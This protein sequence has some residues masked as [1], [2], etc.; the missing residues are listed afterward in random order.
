MRNMRFVLL[1]LAPLMPLALAAPVQA[2]LQSCTVG[3]QVAMPAGYQDKWLQAV[4]I[5]VKPGDTHPC[6]AHPL[7]YTPYADFSYKPSA[8]RAME[9][10]P[11][12]P[13][14]GIVDDPHLLALKGQK[15]FKATRVAT[16]HYECAAFTGGRLEVRPSLEFTI[17][18]KGNY[19]DAFG[20]HGTYAFDASSGAMA[21]RGGALD[22][23]RGY[24]KQAS[25][26]PV[27]TQPPEFNFDVSHD[28]CTM[29]M[30]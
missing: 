22:G 28:T 18:D 14:G 25:D 6:R 3:Q 1:A 12:Q 5:E 4:I 16:G 2:Q 7:G 27:K 10:V 30:R 21:F 8:L 13:I 26:P 17:V 9:S 15:A 11:T 29:A 23:Q 24:Y 19:R 20:G